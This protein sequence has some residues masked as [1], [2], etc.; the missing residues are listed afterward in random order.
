M[1]NTFVKIASVT[2]G[3][4]GASSIDFTSIPSTYTDLV[5]KVSA[6]GSRTDQQFDTLNFVFNGNT[7]AVYTHRN[8]YGLNG[9][10]SSLNGVNVSDT[11]G[12]AYDGTNLATASTFGNAEIYIPNYAGSTNKSQSADSVSEGNSANGPI[13]AL[14]TN[15]FAQTTAISSIKIQQGSGTIVQYS[16][17]TL[18]GIKNS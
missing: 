16:T 2:V 12:M 15:L 18:Y 13:M 6:R 4:G 7:S 8:I 1:A 17:A 9:S 5:V 3:A 11:G 14:G 10:A